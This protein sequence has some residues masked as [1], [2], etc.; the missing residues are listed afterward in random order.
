M[1]R[2]GPRGRRPDAAV[3]AIGYQR[4]AGARTAIAVEPRARPAAAG[5]RHDRPTPVE[6]VPLLA[7]EQR[8]KFGVVQA[9]DLA[10]DAAAAVDEPGV[11]AE[12]E[13]AAAH[14]ADA[15]EGRAVR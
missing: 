15:Q 3:V 1:P 8:Q 2:R 13:Q 7:V 5:E 11:A 14:A 12:I 9:V 4:C 10:A 6:I